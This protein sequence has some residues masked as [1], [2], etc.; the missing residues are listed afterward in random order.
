MMSKPIRFLY[1]VLAMAV[2]LWL[3][4]TGCGGRTPQPTDAG[5][6]KLLIAASIAP[7][8]DFSQQVGGDRVQ[9]E[10]LVPPGASPHTYELTPAQLQ[11]LSKARVLVLNGIGLEFWADDAVNAV[12]NHHL[13]VVDTSQG[14]TILE[15]DSDEP[16]GNPHIWLDPLNAIHQVE[17][18]RDALVQADP[19]GAEIYRANAERYIGE[20]KTLDQEIRGRVATFSSKEFIAFHPA[21]VYFAR[22][23]GLEQ[24]AVIETTPGKEPSPAE[25][26]QIVKTARAI[27]AK[28]IF[29]EPQFSPKAAEVI[30]AESGAEVLFLNPLGDPPDFRYVDMMRR[31]LAE[32]EKALK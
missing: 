25:V 32:M 31:N 17:R 30:A 3:S 8:Y 4:L 10:M 27:G 7:L 2:L 11:T 20:L 14:L 26:A 16:K 23:Y 13:V 24:V 21:W 28:A 9:V 18:I 19:G 29:A 15:G 22:R 1:V 5:T 6:D 12:N